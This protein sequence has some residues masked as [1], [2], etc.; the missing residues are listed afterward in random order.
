YQEMVHKND[1]RRELKPLLTDQKVMDETILKHEM[2]PVKSVSAIIGW[3]PRKTKAC[4]CSCC[5]GK[6][7]RNKTAKERDYRLIVGCGRE[8]GGDRGNI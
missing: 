8:T 6:G 2:T 4:L 5:T 7:R 1:M 3:G